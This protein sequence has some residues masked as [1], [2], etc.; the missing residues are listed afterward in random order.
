LKCPST[1]WQLP[2]RNDE[3]LRRAAARGIEV[4]LVTGR[5]YDF[6]RPVVELVPD[7]R[8]LIVSSGALTKDRDGTTL[9]RHVL[10]RD[11]AGRVLAAT[12]AWRSDMAVVFDRPGADQVIYERIDWDDPRHRVYFDR[13]RDALTEMTPLEV[14]LTEDPIQVMAAGGVTTM[15]GL[16]AHLASLPDRARIEVA[17]T[18]YAERDLTI[19]DVNGAGVSKG[20][21]LTGL[22]RLRGLDR[23]EIMAIGDNMNDHTMLAAAG[24]PVVMANAVPELKAFGWPETASN[25]DAGVAEAIERYILKN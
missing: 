20:A 17:L 22:A 2:P 18:E 19:V 3:A 10:P 13:N 23:T 16:A 4:V 14:C 21:A 7:V 5:R 1:R 15:R 9:A 25:D 24:V 11:M 8:L 12:R 6:A